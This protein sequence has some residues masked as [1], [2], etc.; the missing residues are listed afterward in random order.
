[1][2]YMT[3]SSSVKNAKQFASTGPHAWSLSSA[4]AAN[5]K[6]LIMLC[7][8]PRGNRWLSAAELPVSD[9]IKMHPGERDPDVLVINQ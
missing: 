4:M 8:R 3:S 7:N 5:E 6:L 1:M 9:L 2:I